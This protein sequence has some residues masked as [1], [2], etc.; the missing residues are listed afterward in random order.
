MK[1][2]LVRCS[3]SVLCEVVVDASCEPHIIA[4]AR[5]QM[6]DAQHHHAT[7]VLN[8]DWFAE[9]AE[10]RPLVNTRCIEVRRCLG[11][12][13]AIEWPDLEVHIGIAGLL[14]GRRSGES[15]VSFNRCCMRFAVS[16]VL[17]R[18]WQNHCG[19]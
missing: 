9:P 1:P 3:E 4:I 7:D 14:A 2:Y 19:E 8:S 6:E 16:Q 15:E 5:Q 13:Y 11:G 18:A 17:T 12:G 10:K